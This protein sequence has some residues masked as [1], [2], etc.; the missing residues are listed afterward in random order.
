MNDGG[1]GRG[2][3]TWPKGG[4]HMG[5]ARG[6]F[7]FLA[8]SPIFLRH[9]PRPESV[10][11]GLGN[12]EG[13][14][15]AGGRGPRDRGASRFPPPGVRP[16]FPVTVSCVTAQGAFPLQTPGNLLLKLAQRSAHLGEKKTRPEHCEEKRRRR[17]RPGAERL[18][19]CGRVRSQLTLRQCAEQ[20]P[21][22]DGRC[23][24]LCSGG[25]HRRP[26]CGSTPP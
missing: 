8:V 1:G 11:S 14:L 21:G 19:E 26:P 22:G 6:S 2:V 13:H 5:M 3:Q 17:R 12:P 15:P 18:C 7:S 20:A 24:R 25:G 16:V 23:G 4:G 9:R 10:V